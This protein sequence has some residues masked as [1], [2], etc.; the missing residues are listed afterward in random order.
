MIQKKIVTARAK[1]FSAMDAIDTV[2]EYMKTN[3]LPEK[4]RKGITSILERKLN[5][6]RN[7]TLI[8]IFPKHNDHKLFF[9][10]SFSLN[11]SQTS[12]FVKKGYLRTFEVFSKL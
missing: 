1:T 8:D 5:Y 2:N 6:N 4:H 10:N 11:P 12:E 9:G 7:L 3:N